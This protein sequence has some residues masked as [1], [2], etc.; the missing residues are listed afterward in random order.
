MGADRFTVERIEP[1]ELDCQSPL[2]VMYKLSPYVWR[3]EGGYRI[4]VRAVNHSPYPPEKMARVY[5]GRSEDGLRFVMDDHPVIAPGTGSDD[6]DGCEDPTLVY[7]DGRYYVFYTGWN[8]T[9]KR[10]QLFLAAGKDI[11]RLEKRGVALPS[12]ETHRNPKEATVVAAASGWRLFFE[13]ADDGASKIGVASSPSLDGPWEIGAPPLEARHGNWDGWHLSTGP[14]LDAGRPHPIMFYNG[15]TQDAKWR[16][17]WVEFDENYTRV[18]SRSDD[19]LITPPPG[20]PGDTDIAFAASAVE[21][22]EGVALYYSIAD[23][24]MFRAL[25]VEASGESDPRS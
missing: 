13:Y 17:G 9:A 18:S 14:V 23:R 1:L 8:Q 15:A 5:H 22:D 21:T 16:I 3:E 25:L 6:K 19:P 12:T 11:E 4:L 20:E 10:G 2:D 24:K 7:D